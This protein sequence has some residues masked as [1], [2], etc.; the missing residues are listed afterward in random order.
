MK[1]IGKLICLY[2]FTNSFHCV[3]MSFVDRA[4]K[5]VIIAVYLAVNLNWR[6]WFEEVFLC[7]Q[8]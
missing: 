2:F 8:L 3:K 7:T 4:E 5:V 6:D 1:T